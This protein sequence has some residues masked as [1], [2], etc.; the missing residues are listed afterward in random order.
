MNYWL[1]KTEPSAYS[2]ADLKHDQKATWDGVRNYQARN[3]MRDQMQV[4][5]LCFFYHSMAKPLSIMGIVRISQTGLLDHTAL[6]ANSKYFDQRHTLAKPL[7]YM[8]EVEFVQDFE[9]PITRD[10]LKNIPQLAD[11]ML[12]QKGSRL[13]VQPVTPK[14]W[15]IITALRK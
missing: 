1:L 6:D 5:D 15:D 9:P 3:I 10:S 11:M 13:S 8:V 7:W 14:Q 12:L 2:W 4:G